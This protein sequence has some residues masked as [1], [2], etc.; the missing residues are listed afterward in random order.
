M[1]HELRRGDR[2]LGN[3]AIVE[4]AIVSQDAERAKQAHAKRSVV[5]DELG[6]D[7]RAGS[8]SSSWF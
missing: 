8:E 4:R 1:T 6:V 2:R 7:L 5:S 3:Q